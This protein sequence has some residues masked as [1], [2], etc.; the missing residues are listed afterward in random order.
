MKNKLNLLRIIY[1]CPL[2][3]LIGLIEVP[4]GCEM[5][6]DEVIRESLYCRVASKFDD[7]YLCGWECA[8]DYLE[9]NPLEFDENGDIVPKW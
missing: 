8:L 5:C 4:V 3:L 9:A 2:L 1:L 7:N 6:G